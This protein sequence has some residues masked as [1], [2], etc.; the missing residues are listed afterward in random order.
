MLQ[1]GSLLAAALPRIVAVPPPVTIPV[2]NNGATASP[3]C[4]GTRSGSGTPHRD[5]GPP[6]PTHSENT[7]PH[8]PPLH[9]DTAL[10]RKSKLHSNH[11]D[12]NTFLNLL[13]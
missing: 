1:S 7:D 3:I 8:A 6:T 2:A 10:P 9:L 11:C 5:P 12:V 4:E 13:L